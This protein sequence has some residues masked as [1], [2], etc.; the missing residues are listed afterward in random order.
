MNLSME[1][2]ASDGTVNPANPNPRGVHDAPVEKVPL[3]EIIR[4]FNERWFAGWDMTPEEQRVK[5]I[6]IAQHVANNPDYETQVVNNQDKQN[7][8]LAMEK[9]ISLVVGQ[10]RKLELDL[11]KR[12]ASDP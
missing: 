9:L 5:F 2:D 3:D 4:A 10:E 7:R 1:L 11:Y 12:Y 8:R 6:N